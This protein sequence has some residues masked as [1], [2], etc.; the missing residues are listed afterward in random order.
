[1]TK[2]LIVDDNQLERQG[3]R[4]LLEKQSYDLQI[5]ECSNGLEALQAIKTHPFSLLITDIKMP[6]MNGVDL[7]TQVREFN[8]DIRILVLSGYDDFTYARELL[9]SNVLDYLLKPIDPIEFMACVNQIFETMIGT[10]PLCEEPTIDKVLEIIHQ[11]FHKELTLEELADRVFLS[12][13]YLSILFKKE[14]GIGLNK[15]LNHFR[16]ERAC[17]LLKN[18]NMKVIDIAKYIGFDNPSYFNRLFKNTFEMTPSAYREGIVN[19]A[20]KEVTPS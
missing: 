3:I 13:N 2:I 16:L 10:H 14:M 7:I 8:Q 1:M 19:H 15:Y 6:L 4:F 9:K 12:S 18:S 11:E 20:T 5:E 17:A